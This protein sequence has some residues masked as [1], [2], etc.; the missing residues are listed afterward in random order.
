MMTCVTFAS[1]EVKVLRDASCFSSSVRLAAF[2][3]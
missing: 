1:L 2:M 3:R